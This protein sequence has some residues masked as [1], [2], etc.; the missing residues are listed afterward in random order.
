MV[1]SL[2]PF[3]FNF[4]TGERKVADPA[5]E[6]VAIMLQGVPLAWAQPFMSGLTLTGGDLRGEF[7]VT[8]NNGGVALRPRAPL[9][10]NALNLVKAAQPMLS[11]V[12]LAL[13]LEADYT[14]AGWQ[15]AVTSLTLQ[16]G[17]ANLLT[18]KAKVGQRENRNPVYGLK[19][20]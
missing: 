12:D 9:S 6:L 4:K 16:S 10:I 20:A 11:A 2:Q 17:G 7:A 18:L 3:E 1:Q 8:A 13:D 15:A 5:R 19:L 14:P